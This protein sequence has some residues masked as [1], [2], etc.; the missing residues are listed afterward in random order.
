MTRPWVRLRRQGPEPCALARGGP[1]GEPK[2]G[3]WMRRV[4]CTVSV[5]DISDYTI[6]T[7]LPRGFSLY[8][9]SAFRPASVMCRRIIVCDRRGLGR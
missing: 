3:Y 9:A 4:D 7:P 6:A 5:A 1:A 2:A 8:P